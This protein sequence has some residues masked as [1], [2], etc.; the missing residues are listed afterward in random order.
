MEKQKSVRFDE[1]PP[2]VYVMRTWPY[3]SRQARKGHWEQIG[4]DR[5]RFKRRIENTKN[6][7][8]KALLNKINNL[9]IDK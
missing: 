4:R 1:A 5:E 6:I 9:S 3:A 2:R 7:I 8:E